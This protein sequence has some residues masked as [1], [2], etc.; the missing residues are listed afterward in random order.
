[1]KNVLRKHASIL[2]VFLR[3]IDPGIVISVAYIFCQMDWLH[4]N[5]LGKILSIYCS[6]LVVIIFPFFNIYKS[7]RIETIGQE[8]KT[9]AIAWILVLVIF[10]ALIF[11]VAQAEQRDILLPFCLFSNSNFLSWAFSVFLAIGLS[12][13]SLRTFLRFI[14]RCGW[15]RRTVVIAGAGKVG[16][17]VAEYLQSTEFLGIEVIG[18]FDDEIEK[19]TA[20]K[21]DNGNRL[22]VIGG[23]SDSIQY[24]VK[25]DIDIV[26]ITLPMKAFQK[27]NELVW[28]L[29]LRGI[30]V[31]MAPDLFAFGLQKTKVI[32]VGNT[33]VM[34][35][36]LFPTWKRIFD[37]VFSLFA[38]VIFSPLI[39]LI[40][41]LIK[42]EDGGPVFYGHE[43]I[44]E[45]G[46]T[47]KCLKFRTMH[48][49]SD[50]RLN[51]ILERDPALK[52]EWEHSYKLKNDPRITKIGK[53]LRKTSLDELPQFINILKGEMS[54]V[55]ARPVIKDE[56]D[57]YYNQHALTYCSMKP[58]LTGLWQSGKRS[59]VENY[60]ERVEQDRLYVL[61]ASPGLDIKIIFK[62]AWKMVYGKGAY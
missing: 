3:M 61:K 7:W 25:K 56:L 27:I 58:G 49:N 50:K 47:F 10:N 13:I 38:L 57:R 40:I 28:G 36:N 22:G 11:L 44:R 48:P 5:E 26:F 43:R 42:K 14:R 24:A 60:E 55:G 33:P 53:F 4:P 23:V 52:K 15:N 20:I 1:M 30:I 32:S 12:R 19:G 17:A 59:D 21:L 31:M 51:E 62:T 34:M 18:F 35:F 45:H 46:K 6:I 2:I 41:L 37:F 54:I 16:K 29:G 8:I 39:G 9:I